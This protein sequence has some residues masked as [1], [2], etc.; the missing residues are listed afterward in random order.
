[1]TRGAL[2]RL[3]Q[4]VSATLPVGAYSYSQG[5]EWAVGSGAVRDEASAGEWIEAVLEQGIAAWDAPWVAALMRAAARGAHEELAE[6]NDRFL[7]GRETR[8]LRAETVQTG[9][10]LLELLRDAGEL[11][12]AALR[13]LEALDAGRGLAFP[14]AWATAAVARGIAVEDALVGYLWSWLENSVLAALKTVPLGQRAGQRLL[15]RLGG[16]L[17]ALAATAAER[18][19]DSCSNLLPGFALASMHH[20][21]QYTRLF[22]S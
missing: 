14:T 10:S 3:L 12:P 7:A 20:E 2:P 17:E 9:R 1:M 16:R 18:P 11:A 5:L 19:L 6:L 13:G 21:T 15:T 4:L 8:E 22:R